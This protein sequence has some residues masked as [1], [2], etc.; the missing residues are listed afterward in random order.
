M[1]KRV[2]AIAAAMIFALVA[3]GCSSGTEGASETASPTTTASTSP[4]TGGSTGESPDTTEVAAAEGDF[5]INLD[6]PTVPAGEVTFRINNEGP[7]VHEF[8]VFKTDL[9]PG[10]LPT[11]EGKVDEEG[12]QGLGEKEDVQVGS[13][14]DLTLNLPAGNYVV[15]CN[16]PGHYSA[17]MYASIKT[18]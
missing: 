2:S 5:Y 15:V 18:T 6:Q 12:L 13:E 10:N 9:A 4:T 1:I 3:I 14:E 7:S 11:S 17:G 8:V 16:L